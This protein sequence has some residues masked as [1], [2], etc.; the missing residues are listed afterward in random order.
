MAGIRKY[1]KLPEDIEQIK[2]LEIKIIIKKVYFKI[3]CL[4]ISSNKTLKN[5]N[6]VFFL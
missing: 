5:V 2:E 3:N 6:L 4:I 1:R